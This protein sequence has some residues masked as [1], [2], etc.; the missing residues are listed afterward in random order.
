MLALNSMIYEGSV[1]NG[2]IEIEA[3][4]SKFEGSEVEIR[5]VKD[6]RTRKQ[7]KALHLYFTQ[8]A[9]ALNE[10]GLDMRKVLKQSVDIPWTAERV[11][12][13]LWRPVQKTYLN[14]ESTTELNKLKE[15]D[16]I[17]EILNRHLSEKFGIYIPFPSVETL[18]EEELKENEEIKNNN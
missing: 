16:E 7:N 12:E 9:N 4:L 1:R 8:V 5:I 15:I 10:A 18:M 3:D 14:K 6:K 11:K 17:W 13:F 2:K